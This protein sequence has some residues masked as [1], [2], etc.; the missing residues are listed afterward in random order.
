MQIKL[1]GRISKMVKNGSSFLTLFQT[2]APDAY[3]QP[4]T[5][6]VVSS[7]Q[8]G[9]PGDELNLTCSVRS[10]VK[11]KPYKEKDTGIGKEFWEQ[12]IM[13]DV[14]SFEAVKSPVKQVS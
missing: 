14:V 8:L 7:D 10:W 3:S 11:I 1:S 2:P 12:N 6:K 13:F 4:S 9:Q 5:Y